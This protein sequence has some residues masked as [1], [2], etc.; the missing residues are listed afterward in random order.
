[1]ISLK[2]MNAYSE[3]TLIFRPEH[4]NGCRMCLT[5]CPHGVFEVDGKVVKIVH[6][7]HCMECGACQQNCPTGA[8]SVNSGVGCATA[9]FMAALRGKK[10][11]ACSCC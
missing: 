11:E 10:E 2:I 3:N 1:M 5:V 9:M 4:C 7:F 8:L 6:K